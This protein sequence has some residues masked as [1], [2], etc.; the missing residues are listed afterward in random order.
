MVR[1]NTNFFVGFTSNLGDIA[2]RL[3]S[4]DFFAQKGIVDKEQGKVTNGVLEDSNKICGG[5]MIQDFKSFKLVD[6]LGDGIKQLLGIKT[7]KKKD[8]S[9]LVLE[10]KVVN[11]DG[12]VPTGG[13]LNQEEITE[14]LE[15]QVFQKTR[16][17][18]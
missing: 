14:Q 17:L 3:M 10:I 7:E 1:R 9:G 13:T 6:Y 16:L 11:F 2:T 5:W 15:Q 8:Q 18:Q 12:N 4:F